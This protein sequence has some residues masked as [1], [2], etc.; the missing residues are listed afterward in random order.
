MFGSKKT[1]TDRVKDV[2]TEYMDKKFDDYRGQI[3]MDLSRGLAG[4]AGL[5]A[6]WTLF[7]VCTMF[8]S[9]AIALLLGWVLSFW[10]SS[11]GFVISFI[12]IAIVLLSGAVYLFLHKEKYIEDHV[13]KVVSETLRNPDTWGIKDKT[14][15]EKTK[16]STVSEVKKDVDKPTSQPLKQIS[17][18]EKTMD[19][20][21]QNPTDTDEE[22]P[23]K[24]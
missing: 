11:L 7:I 16:E 22:N 15:K 21:K 14:K 1:I 20:P 10:L 8:G 3:A 24:N 23:P 17:F 12:F 18:A 4:L 13:Y 9:F 2:L 6:I 5:V 19:E